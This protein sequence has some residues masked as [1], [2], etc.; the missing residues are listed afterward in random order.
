[1]KLHNPI[2]LLNPL[3]PHTE[4]DRNPADKDDTCS[5]WEDELHDA[6]EELPQRRIRVIVPRHPTLITGD[7]SEEN[8]SPYQRRAHQT[9]EASVVPNNYQ[10]A[11]N[12][13]DCNKWE[14]EISK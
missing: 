11:I 2:S 13:K 14:E 8:I 6:M 12:S 10:H 4:T 1:M 9:V 5:E 7:I 3:S